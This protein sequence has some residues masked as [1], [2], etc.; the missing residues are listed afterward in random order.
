V[1]GKRASMTTG[2]R[3]RATTNSKSMWQMMRAMTKRAR[4]TRAM[5][6]AMRVPGDK[7]G[8]GGKGHSIS[9]EGG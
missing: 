1:A 2:P 8:K 5:V 7:E 4:G 3:R 9:N 6:T